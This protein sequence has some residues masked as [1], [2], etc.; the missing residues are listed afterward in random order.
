MSYA[1]GSGTDSV[2]DKAFEDH[3]R[4]DILLFSVWTGFQSSGTGY[5]TDSLEAELIPDLD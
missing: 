2:L 1:L 5:E 4:I 3:Y